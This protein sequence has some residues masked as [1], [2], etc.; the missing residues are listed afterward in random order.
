MGFDEYWNCSPYRYRFY[1]EAHTLKAEQKNQE[2]WAQGLYFYQGL[3]AALHNALSTKGTPEQ[4]LEKPLAIRPPTKAEQ[5]R[6]EEKE[7]DK[8]V[9]YLNT[10]RKQ[11]ERTNGNV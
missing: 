6:K 7:L 2:M 3:T 11:W 8:L 10:F 1:R 4:Y 9:E 5:E